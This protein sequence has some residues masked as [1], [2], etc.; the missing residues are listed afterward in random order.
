MGITTAFL[1][2]YACGYEPSFYDTYVLAAIFI[3]AALHVFRAETLEGCVCGLLSLYCGVAV[4]LHLQTGL[5]HAD[6]PGEFDLLERWFRG[7]VWLA[8][9]SA[10]A[11]GWLC[12]W[13]GTRILRHAPS[14]RERI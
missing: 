1:P 3:L 7:G 10:M 13:G 4:A 5:C 14:A 6:Y 8:A 2:P 11:I 9:S 12:A